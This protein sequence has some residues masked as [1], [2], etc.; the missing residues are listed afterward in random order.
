M[1]CDAVI[2]NAL[3]GTD[4][5]YASVGYTLGANVENLTLTGAGTIDGTGNTLNNVIRGNAPANNLIMAA[6]AMISCTAMRAPTRLPAATG[7][8]CWT[9][10]LAPIR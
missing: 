1:R 9:A 10:G 2:E 3:E 5:V 6:T 7:S 4:L 8:T